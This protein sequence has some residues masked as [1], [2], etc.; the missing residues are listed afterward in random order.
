MIETDGLP[1]I[2]TYYVY[3]GL[4]WAA[5]IMDVISPMWRFGRNSMSS[6]GSI[7]YTTPMLSVVCVKMPPYW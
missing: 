3:L 6:K 5:S 2:M 7:T 4:V 1:F